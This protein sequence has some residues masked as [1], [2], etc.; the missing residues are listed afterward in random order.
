MMDVQS[1]YWQVEV[2]PK[3]RDKTSFCT[4]SGLY[5]FNVLPFG[6]TNAPATFERLMETVLRGLQ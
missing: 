6:L 4:R 5:Q 3:D 2:D 1:G